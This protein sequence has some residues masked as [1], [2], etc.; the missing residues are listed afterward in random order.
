MPSVVYAFQE[1]SLPTLI[2]TSPSAYFNSQ[3]KKNTIKEA[4]THLSFPTLPYKLVPS[5]I[6]L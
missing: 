3:L 1:Q 6:L 4:S 2:L 5:Y